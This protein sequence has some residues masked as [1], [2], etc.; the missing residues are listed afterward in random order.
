MIVAE[1]GQAS[2]FERRLH[3]KGSG[4]ATPKPGHVHYVLFVDQE[5]FLIIE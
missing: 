1:Y 5:L 4:G 2:I 3:N